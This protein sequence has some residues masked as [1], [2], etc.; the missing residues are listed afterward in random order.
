[1]S[2]LKIDHLGVA[3]SLINGRPLTDDLLE[4]VLLMLTRLD[5][6][7]SPDGLLAIKLKLESTIG[8]KHST[9][10]VIRESDHEPWVLDL[11]ATTKD[12]HYWDSY[13][14]LLKA[15]GWSGPI[16]NV[17][18][19]DTDNI[20]TECGNPEIKEGWRVRGLVMGDVQSGK[21]ASYSG[22]IA[23]AG[24]AGYK[25]IVLL[26]GIIEDLRKQTQER[27]D[28]GFVGL[29]SRDVL[30]PEMTRTPVGA[31]IYRSRFANV[32][33]SV[34]SDFLTGNSRALRGIPLANI[35]EPV[36]FVMK[37]NKTSLTNLNNWLT[38]QLENGATKHDL[39]LLLLDDEADNAS[40]NANKDENPATINKLIREVLSKFYRSSYVAYTATPFANVFINPDDET[41]LFPSN[42]I[43]SLNTPT[44][45]IGAS[46][47]F[48]E[49]GNHFEQLLYIDDAENILPYSHKIDHKLNDLPDTLK[50]AIRAFF[51][52]CAIRD[53][54]KENLKHRSML[55][56]V[57]RFTNVQKE[58]ADQISLVMTGL[59]E[60]IKQYLLSPGWDKHKVLSDLYEIWKE[61]FS[62][63]EFTWEQIRKAL[64]EAT[65]SIKV[66]TI[67][68]RSKEEKL[69]YSQ[70][71]NTEKG[72]RVIAVGGM[73]LS[74]GI[75]LEGLC[76]SYFYRNSKAYDTLLQM[77]RWFGYRTGY[78]DL[79]RIWMDVDTQGWYA[80]IATAVEELKTDFRRM[81]ANRQPPSKF[82]IRVKSH[83]DTLMVTAQNKMRN[84][85][86]IVHSI[87]FSS[88]GTETA[89][90]PR[91]AILNAQNIDRT[92]AFIKKL[93]S[94]DKPKQRFI[95]KA[96][97]KSVA[98]FLR[99]L[100]IHRS[101]L[102]FIED[103][104]SGLQPLI[105]FI[106]DNKYSSLSE[107]DVS[108]P[109]G[110]G[111]IV[112]G[113]QIFATDGS[114]NTVSC[115]TRQFEKVNKSADF[116]RLN[117][118]RVGDT[119]DELV[120]MDEETEIN[121]ANEAWKIE[122]DR[123]DKKG[124]RVPAYFYRKFRSRP[125][126]TIHFINCVAPEDDNKK[127]SMMDPTEVESKVLIAISMSFPDF[128]P[129]MQAEPIV[130]R[131]NKI[132]TRALFG[133]ASESE[134]DDED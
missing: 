128:D 74:R 127:P 61:Q 104:D 32:L 105:S 46:S 82:G 111:T 34:D 92:E 12:W 112:E 35:N 133:E 6:E 69:D 55:V 78:D 115:R 125:L 130:Y 20:L 26:T 14:L 89:Y 121:A 101:N 11:K 88:Y 58:V 22:L 94:A 132:A 85:E 43:Y 93:G 123:D 79:F 38:K 31:G 81:S 71:K 67:N 64:Y 13:K 44:N 87:S 116:L 70:Y 42:F 107:W 33:T 62:K 80:H 110:K 96:D 91:S 122:K 37:K 66:M 57:S 47:I 113:L 29:N 129:K 134:E 95:W 53:L 19:E 23:K 4:E 16:L 18:D 10:S 7:L 75:T 36:L 54:R 73:T 25:V 72:R 117:K 124:D 114:G 63:T 40:V 90:L 2:T 103:P 59:Q 5:A 9:G 68:Q 65:A 27:L 51:I 120:G 17:L 102:A 56:N 28:E 8:I 30:G 21:T 108:I 39:P 97:Q 98:D 131:M 77:G 24:D 109:Q 3:M 49:D 60:E 100:N 41:D 15:S 119:S 126:L 45:Y 84:A 118:L 52:I 86:E 83:P 50:Q 106:A 1:M 48:L 76:C 99:E